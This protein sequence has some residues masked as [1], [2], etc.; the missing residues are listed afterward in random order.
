MMAKKGED[1][2]AVAGEQ[3]AE[4][5]RSALIGK[6]VLSILGQPRDF[7]RVQVRQLWDDRF[8]ANIYIGN[9]AV[10]ATV[11]DSFFLIV[12]QQG[13]ILLSAPPIKRRY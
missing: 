9:D 3:Q 11:A 12:D 13:A 1:T 2:L 6:E 8:R 5:K 7:Q 4:N 10:S